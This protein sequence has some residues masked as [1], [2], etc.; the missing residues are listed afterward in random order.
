MS[1]RQDERILVKEDSDLFQL[2]RRLTEEQPPIEVWDALQEREP[3]IQV[4]LPFFALL[5]AVDQLPT[6]KARLLYHRLEE[7]LTKTMMLSP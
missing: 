6:E 7:R 4:E 5:N 2:V 1:K 3:L